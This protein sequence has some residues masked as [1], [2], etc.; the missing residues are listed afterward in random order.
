MKQRKLEFHGTSKRDLL[1]FPDP[2]MK[3]AGYQLRK[4]QNGMEPSDW[5]Y[6]H[7]VGPGTMEIRIWE[8]GDTFRVFY[9][10]RHGDSVHVLHCFQKKTNE[11][12]QRDIDIAKKRYKEIGG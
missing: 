3:A 4:V 5:K 8:N 6:V 2:A 7:N 9:V 12:Q 1:K 10:A 11:T